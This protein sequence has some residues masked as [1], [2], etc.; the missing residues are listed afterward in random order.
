MYFIQKLAENS[1][2]DQTLEVGKKISF[3]VSLPNS[4][5]KDTVLNFKI[6]GSFL[7]GVNDLNMSLHAGLIGNSGTSVDRQWSIGVPPGQLAIHHTDRVIIDTGNTV[8]LANTGIWLTV[9]NY[10]SSAVA[11][12]ANFMCSAWFSTTAYPVVHDVN[13]S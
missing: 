3:G 10:S 4:N 1:S 11:W 12:R 5:V 9:S 2:S 8:T 13:A 6:S 7:A